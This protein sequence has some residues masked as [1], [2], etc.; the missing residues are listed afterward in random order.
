V[1]D[2][3]NISFGRTALKEHA[4]LQ[5]KQLK[6]SLDS[7]PQEYVYR[8]L[9]LLALIDPNMSQEGKL[10]RLEADLPKN[11]KGNIIK[12][13]GSTA[14]NNESYESYNPRFHKMGQNKTGA[15]GDSK[16]KKFTAIKDRVCYSCKKVGHIV[17]FCPDKDKNQ[18]K[19]Q[20]SKLN[21]E[22]DSSSVDN[23]VNS[24][25]EN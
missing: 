2:L 14:E 15:K 16:S 11:I 24:D 8:K 19:K 13:N 4:K 20:V 9:E 18:S 21:A 5:A 25:S 22:V 10:V 3:M 6:F 23:N 12:G 1:K 7:D 17:R